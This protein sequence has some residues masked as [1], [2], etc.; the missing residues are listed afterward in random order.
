MSQVLHT[1]ESAIH[2]HEQLIRLAQ[3][4][5]VNANNPNYIK[6]EA[7]VVS[8]PNLGAVI[9]D[10]RLAITDGLLEEQYTRNSEFSAS[11]KTLELLK[12]T[13]KTLYNL[14]L[15]GKDSV[16]G[17]LGNF[18]QALINYKAPAMIQQRWITL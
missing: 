16:P 14:K 13:L 4:N 8:N 10:I 9:K 12:G 6:Q 18:L 1:T 2:N 7:T 3:Q 15:D 17:T 11:S 5:I